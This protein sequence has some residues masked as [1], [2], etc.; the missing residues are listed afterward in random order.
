MK[1][2]FT[3]QNLVNNG[4]FCYPHE[5]I[6]DIALLK[7]VSP[8]EYNVNVKPICLP[9]AGFDINNALPVDDEKEGPVCI[10]SGWGDTKGT[11]DENHLQQATLPV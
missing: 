2:W 10:I 9:R 11:A 6:K 4:Q 8:L 5:V 3:N 1:M 7:L